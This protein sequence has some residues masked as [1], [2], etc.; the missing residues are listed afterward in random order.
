MYCCGSGREIQLQLGYSERE[1]ERERER[2][3]LLWGRE[4][5]LLAFLLLVFA[6]VRRG[7]DAIMRE[8]SAKEGFVSRIIDRL[9]H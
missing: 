2:E 3:D 8:G 9:C 5:M 4:R 1:R 7:A 6:Q